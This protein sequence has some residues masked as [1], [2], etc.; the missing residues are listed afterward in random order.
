MKI[1][2]YIFLT[3]FVLSQKIP[4]SAQVYDFTKLDKLLQD[5]VNSASGTGG[6]Y[7]LVLIKDGKNIY[8]KS[9]TQSGKIYTPDKI[10]PIASAS[11]WL[12]AGVIMSLVDDGK[13]SLDDS[14]GKFLSYA[15]G[16]KSH[17]TIRQMF[18]HTAGYL[19]DG[20]SIDDS[21]LGAKIITLDSATR[22]I[23]AI[24]PME[25]TPGNGFAYGGRSMQVAGRCAEIASGLNIPSGKCWDSLFARKISTPLGLSFTR[26]DIPGYPC[27]DP[28]IGGGIFSSANDYAKYLQMILDKGMYQGNRI[29]SEQ[30]VREM[31]RN[32]T[33]TFKIYYSPYAALKFVLPEI[34]ANTRYGIGNWRESVNKIT[35]EAIESSSQGAFGFSPWIDQQRNLV[36]VLSVY[37][38]LI[39][40]M[41]TYLEMKKLIKEILDSPAGI[42][43]EKLTADNEN[44]FEIAPNPA[45]ESTLIRFYLPKTEKI[46]LKIFDLVGNEIATIADGEYSAG[47]H[48]VELLLKDKISQGMYSIV[49]KTKEKSQT[50][51]FFLIR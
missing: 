51:P 35:Y 27:D 41:P 10:V 43:E 46:S 29:F 2:F 30:S 33:G 25:Y 23:I 37:S 22:N 32:Q 4:V 34:D 16:D 42:N 7:S 14:A 19:E 1:I 9:F 8:S 6:G 45:F 24:A 20:K 3:L 49:L 38:Q 13:W 31:L 11:K 39:D 44:S 5:S 36:G 26:Y 28:R 48:E 17:A 50:K 18:S 21:L 47:Q 15:S 12:S 40:V